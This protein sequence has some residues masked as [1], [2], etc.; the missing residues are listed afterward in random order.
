MNFD[1]SFF[2]HITPERIE[3]YLVSKGW[4]LHRLQPK[5]LRTRLYNSPKVRYAQI[6]V[7]LERGI[8]YPQSVYHIIKHLSELESR[9][10][11]QVL[12]DLQFFDCEVI[13]YR[14]ILP[15]TSGGM[16]PI[17]I[18]SDCLD[19]IVELLQSSL[20]DVGGASRKSKTDSVR[21]NVLLDQT[22]R[23]SYVVKIVCPLHAISFN[24][25]PFDKMNAGDT[26]MRM[27][28]K[29][30][31][32][33]ASDVVSAVDGRRL[34]KFIDKM[35]NKSYPASVKSF[36]VLSK[37]QLSDDGSVDLNIRWASSL[38]MN[39]NI[40]STVQILPQHFGGISEVVH[41]L[42]PKGDDPALPQSERFI[43]V[44]DECKGY[45]NSDGLREG[46]VIFKTFSLEGKT[47]R[48]KA[49]LPPEQYQIALENHGQKKGNFLEV[50]GKRIMKGRLDE[51]VDV[52]KISPL[53][54]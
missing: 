3:Q 50:V 19:T 43:A 6:E 15:Q 13:R 29:H 37:M 30:I 47:V 14:L 52:E 9:D 16:I 5:G 39:E 24:V 11:K 38:E 51:I 10:E 40:P 2:D 26:V 27:A 45:H 21:E 25:L 42:S 8:Y 46:D 35:A 33:T 28:T 17:G 53:E 4:K 49:F 1:I 23:G 20:N 48:A 22:E 41:A 54:K 7:P 34:G 32:R 18:G 36:N 44:V 31:M 12:D